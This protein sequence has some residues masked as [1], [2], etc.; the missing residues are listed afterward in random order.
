MGKTARDHSGLIPAVRDRVSRPVDS[1]PCVWRAAPPRVLSLGEGGAE[2]SG[3][4]EEI[5]CR[6]AFNSSFGSV[7]M[8]SCSSRVQHLCVRARYL[9]AFPDYVHVSTLTCNAEAAGIPISLRLMRRRKLTAA[10]GLHDDRCKPGSAPQCV[11][12]RSG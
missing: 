8:I 12:D 4:T 2:A 1:G 5:Q 11:S 3:S 9:F 7:A 6:L 10:A